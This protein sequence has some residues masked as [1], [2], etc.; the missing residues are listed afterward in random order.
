[1]PTSQYSLCRRR[2]PIV[3]G[4]PRPREEKRVIGEE[5]LGDRLM[6]THQ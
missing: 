1:V 2:R 4:D 6:F 5:L 3:K